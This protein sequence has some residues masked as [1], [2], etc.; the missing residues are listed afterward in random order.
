MKRFVITGLPC[1]AKKWEGFLGKKRGQRIIPIREV[2]EHCASPDPRLMSRY[3]T[4]QI[5]K[6]RPESIVCH[7]LG[8]PLTFMALGRIQRKDPSYRPRVTAFNGAFRRVNVFKANHIIRVQFMSDRMAIR[9]VQSRGGAVDLGLR[10]YSPRIRAMYR[11]ILLF[12]ITEQIS[13]AFGLDD[14]FGIKAIKKLKS[15]V[16]I[17]A[18]PNDPYLPYE[19][20]RRLAKDFGVRR[21]HTVKYG[22][23]PYSVPRNRILPLVEDFEKSRHLH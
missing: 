19:S 7:D 8:V 18:S 11:L 10:P 12:R 13:S 2:F 1:P 6:A 14:L 15:P 9:E 17:I 23:F 22:H 3:I 16:Q 20:V 21:F 5:E 4:Q